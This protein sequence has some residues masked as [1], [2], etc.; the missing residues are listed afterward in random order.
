MDTGLAQQTPWSPGRHVP[1]K[2][3]I[4]TRGISIAAEN[5]DLRPPCAIVV[6]WRTLAGGKQQELGH[7]HD[8]RIR[9]N[10]NT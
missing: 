1:H 6:G 5:A 8:T 10:K 7:P 4:L 9:H 2:V 3:A